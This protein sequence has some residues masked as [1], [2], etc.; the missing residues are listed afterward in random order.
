MRS[1]KARSWRFLASNA[2]P[3]PPFRCSTTA[4]GI[5]WVTVEGAS[6]RPR[7]RRSIR[8]A[9]PSRPVISRRSAYRSSPARDFEER[10]HLSVEESRRNEARVAI[11]TENFAKRYFKDGRAVGMRIGMGDGSRHEADHRDCRHRQ[12][13]A[14]RT[15]VKDEV[16]YVERF[17]SE[18]QRRRCCN[19]RAGS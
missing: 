1:L 4:A 19:S 8:I 3:T 13:L 2:S 16:P 7:T 11:V 5:E 14:L 15:D 9:M 6:R 12:G 10:D 17:Q 18:Q